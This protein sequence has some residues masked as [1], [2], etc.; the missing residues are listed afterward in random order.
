MSNIIRF[1]KAGIVEAERMARKERDAQDKLRKLLCTKA[2]GAAPLTDEDFFIVQGVFKRNG[3]K[4]A[5]AYFGTAYLDYS[6]F[7]L[8]EVARASDDIMRELGNGTDKNS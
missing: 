7:F 2:S 1:D 8:N 5:H 4:H 6:V 3:A